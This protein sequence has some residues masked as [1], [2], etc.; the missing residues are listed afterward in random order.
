MVL[1]EQIWGLSLYAKDVY[2]FKCLT[3]QRRR[4]LGN[5][6]DISEG[7]AGG[8]LGK[9][10]LAGSNVSGVGMAQHRRARGLRG[11]RDGG[12]AVSLTIPPSLPSLPPSPAQMR[13]RCAGLTASPAACL[14]V[15]QPRTT[16]TA[17]NSS[18]ASSIAQHSWNVR[19]LSS[20]CPP[21]QPTSRAQAQRVRRQMEEHSMRMPMNA[22]FIPFSRTSGPWHANT[23]GLPYRR[24]DGSYCVSSHPQTV[25]VHCVSRSMPRFLHVSRSSEPALTRVLL[26][27]QDSRPCVHPAARLPSCTWSSSRVS[28]DSPAACHP[29]L[30]SSRL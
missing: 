27:G 2:R 3:G 5:L 28:F 19:N 18:R 9:S 1:S 15:Q 6:G 13:R 20:T 25:C 29:G 10:Q 8:M 23:P 22:P 21:E 17:T 14:R 30:C 26:A 7:K 16:T 24:R 4:G 12:G 11:K